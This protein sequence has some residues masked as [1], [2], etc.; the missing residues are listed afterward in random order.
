MAATSATVFSE[1]SE[2][3]E[4]QQLIEPHEGPLT[5][6]QRE[7]GF[8]KTPNSIPRS[9]VTRNLVKG[10]RH[11]TTEELAIKQENDAEKR[12]NDDLRSLAP[13]EYG[14]YYCIASR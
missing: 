12:L 5:A 4:T 11:Q 8:A 3:S 10:F 7:A 1:S 2:L 6:E 13:D 14:R 9:I